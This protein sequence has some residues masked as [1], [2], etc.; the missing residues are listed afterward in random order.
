[1]AYFVKYFKR[2]RHD[3]AAKATKRSKTN[4][5]INK[6]WHTFNGHADCTLEM[7]DEPLKS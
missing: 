3:V 1:M 6:K 7:R 4:K 2:I 5:Q